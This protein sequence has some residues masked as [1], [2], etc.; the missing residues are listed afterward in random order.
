MKKTGFLYDER[1]LLH[2]PG[3]N[4][5]EVSERLVAIYQG[6]EDSGLLQYLNRIKTSPAELKWIEAVHLVSST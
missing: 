6:I 4:H 5:P 1:F 3:P 2:C